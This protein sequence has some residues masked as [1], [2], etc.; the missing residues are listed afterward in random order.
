MPPIPP[1]KYSNNF[2]V[3]AG[4]KPTPEDYSKFVTAARGND[5]VTLRAMLLK[6]DKTLLTHRESGGDTALTWA[7]WMGHKETVKLLLEQGADIDQPG[8]TGRPAVSWAAMGGR[9][10]VIKLLIAEGASTDI[11][12]NDGR[13]ALILAQMGRHEAAEKALLEGDSTRSRAAQAKLRE[14][15]VRKLHAAQLEA[16]KTQRPNFKLK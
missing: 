6:H 8:M 16:L 10:E 2:N 12:D 13:T 1:N 9:T 7:A 15:E 14:E 4:V 5:V 3:K 11:K